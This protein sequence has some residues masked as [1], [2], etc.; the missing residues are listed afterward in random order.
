MQRRL[1]MDET[2]HF[3]VTDNLASVLMQQGEFE[4]AEKLYLGVLA[5]RRQRYGP[6]DRDVGTSLVG[7]QASAK[8]VRRASV[9]SPTL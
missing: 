9:S 5:E 2:Y 3:R 1:E 7:H 4:E 8:V 6:E